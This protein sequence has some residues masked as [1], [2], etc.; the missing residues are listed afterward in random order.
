[1]PNI[2]RIL[3]CIFFSG[4]RDVESLKNF[5]LDEAWK[6]AEKRLAMD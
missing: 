5:V 2:V 6:L 1:M 3:F 4:K